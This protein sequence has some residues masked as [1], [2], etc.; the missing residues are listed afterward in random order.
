MNANERAKARWAKAP[1]RCQETRE[2]EGKVLMCVKDEHAGNKHL[3]R[4]FGQWW[5]ADERGPRAQFCD[6]DWQDRF[7]E[8]PGAPAFYASYEV[9]RDVLLTIGTCGSVYLTKAQYK[10]FT[11]HLREWADMIDGYMKP[12]T[13]P[14]EHP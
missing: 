5:V 12:Y 14:V 13:Q 7:T 1:K 6:L 8:N 3:D 10:A 4:T 11:D 9:G 2:V